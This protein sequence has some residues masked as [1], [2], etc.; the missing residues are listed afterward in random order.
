MAKKKKKKG[1]KSKK[2]LKKERAAAEKARAAEEAALE[3]A[4]L[5]AEAE[6]EAARLAAEEAIAAEVARQEAER[7]A[8]EEAERKAK[9][10]QARKRQALQW[11]A[12]QNADK[13]AQRRK[14]ARAR[15]RS[16]REGL[17]VTVVE[18]KLW[19]SHPFHVSCTVTMSPTEHTKTTT[20]LAGA[21]SHPVWGLPASGAPVEPQP[22][23]LAEP[24]APGER[25]FFECGSAYRR[26]MV[27]TLTIEVCDDARGTVGYASLPLQDVA[28]RRFL[29]FETL[30]K[31]TVLNEQ[32]RRKAARK[33]AKAALERARTEAPAK[34]LL[35]LTVETVAAQ[36]GVELEDAAKPPD[37]SSPAALLK[38]Q[39]LRQE[40]LSLDL[41]TL[42]SRALA[43]G[44][45]PTAML[46]VTEAAAAEVL[47]LQEARKEELEDSEEE[48]DG[49]DDGNGSESGS[50]RPSS[51]S[52]SG[53]RRRSSSSSTP[54]RKKALRKGASPRKGS[55]RPSTTPHD[56]ETRVNTPIARPGST[57]AHQRLNKGARPES[58]KDD[59][60]RPQSQPHPA[61]S[62]A[63]TPVTRP[64]STKAHQRL[65][66]GTKSR[67]TPR[68]RGSTPGSSRSRKMKQMDKRQKKKDENK[69][70]EMLGA[71]KALTLM[72]GGCWFDR[73]YDL[74]NELDWL[75]RKIWVKLRD[76]AGQPDEPDGSAGKVFL[77]LRA[78]G[79]EI[80][81]K[82]GE[83]MPE[84]EPG[85]E[86][87]DKA[88]VAERRRLWE[89]DRA[90]FWARVASAPVGRIAEPKPRPAL[91]AGW[92][93]G[94]L[95]DGDLVFFPS[96]V[97]GRAEVTRVQLLCRQ[98]N[99]DG[100][101]VLPREETATIL[102]ELGGPTDPDA[103]DEAMAAMSSSIDTERDEAVKLVVTKMLADKPDGEGLEDEN[104]EEPVFVTTHEL[105]RWWMRRFYAP[106]VP[107]QTLPTEPLEQALS[108]PGGVPDPEDGEL[109]VRIPVPPSV[110]RRRRRNADGS[111]TEVGTLVVPADGAP[112]ALTVGAGASEHSLRIEGSG[113]AVG[114]DVT[115]ELE[116]EAYDG[117]LQIK[118]LE[119][120]QQLAGSVV[121]ISATSAVAG[122][123][124]KMFDAGRVRLRLP[125]CHAGP[126]A[127]LRV[128][129]ER[130]TVSGWKQ[131]D[132]GAAL[133]D[134]DGHVTFVAPR[135]GRFVVARA[136]VDPKAQRRGAAPDLDRV[137]ILPTPRQPAGKLN[138]FEALNFSLCA[139]PHQ[140][141]LLEGLVASA[142]LGDL[143][144]WPVMDAQAESSTGFGVSS[145]GVGGPFVVVRGQSVGVQVVMPTEEPPPSEDPADDDGLSV[146]DVQTP[147]AGSSQ[148]LMRSALNSARS[149]LSSA[150][151]GLSSA[152]A[153][154]SSARASL[155]SARAFSGAGSSRGAR[156]ADQIAMGE[157]ELEALR[158]ELGSMRARALRKRALAEGIE[159]AQ[160]KQA[161]STR[162]SKAALVELIMEKAEAEAKAAAE[163]A[164]APPVL[165]IA[166]L[167]AETAFV[168]LNV[169]PVEW[170][171]QP[172]ATLKLGMRIE[173]D[174]STVKAKMRLPFF[175]EL[176]FDIP[177]LE[178]EEMARM[179]LLDKKQETEHQQAGEQA[180]ILQAAVKEEVVGEPARCLLSFASD[181]RPWPKMFAGDCLAVH[182]GE[183]GA[184]ETQT[185]QAEAAAEAAAEHAAATKL[186]KVWRGK[187]GRAKQL[188]ALFMQYDYDG[189]GTLERE[190]VSSL[191]KKL[192]AAAELENIDLTMARMTGMET[193]AEDV[194]MG[195][196]I[197]A[198]TT[199]EFER[200]WKRRGTE[201][202]V[203]GASEV[204]Y[205]DIHAAHL[206]AVQEAAD[207]EARAQKVALKDRVLS[208]VFAM[209]TKPTGWIRRRRERDYVV[210]I[211]DGVVV[212]DVADEKVAKLAEP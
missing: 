55:G 60:G 190:E 135:Q 71:T 64:G 162:D 59:N 173:A 139:F 53:S 116:V 179:A 23:P 122:L 113:A 27:P 108:L 143:T 6:I 28:R 73:G 109:S 15:L 125:H 75:D 18:A 142:G 34:A 102:A 158:V 66:K 99:L 90:A 133:A 65:N 43:C 140:S 33:E 136:M 141:G 17:T 196:A 112:A 211:G 2:E 1:K 110:P 77:R 209:L 5:A 145:V 68:S 8:K 104:E 115:L 88:E 121:T 184:D 198:V 93:C 160:V 20:T 194:A 97:G 41:P 54:R 155:S 89:D 176:T 193:L 165:K 79:P 203:E 40:L 98:H 84:P 85:L 101:G 187:V 14:A 50:D 62:R 114:G 111:L 172:A 151:S 29:D 94:E 200:W 182:L 180:L 86:P 107:T 72:A 103:V 144:Q 120:R 146:S 37:E 47:A 206:Q 100:S 3:E 147:R 32:E 208:F 138:T 161:Q 134:G 164:M 183:I 207:A 45:S 11:A 152:R 186:Q 61:N 117:T 7:R 177:K 95:E 126:P 204:V 197:P 154:L 70:L 22:D 21:C 181:G 166:E 205:G 24:T 137:F 9:E 119:P 96:T 82:R 192:G 91:P 26:G 163:A 178:N 69:R 81:D 156:R 44:V 57:K 118:G 87:L 35:D 202:S 191:L 185:A 31:T 157:A 159:E 76:P 49:D 48:E 199:V 212:D 174:E 58:P 210:P 12:A 39:Q 67:G 131:I 201:K 123:A 30:A 25:L 195:M 63:N 42:K 80:Q 124:T 106:A 78:C 127:R 129:H 10:L 4:R 46:E 128:L 13:E 105:E 168:P 148:R 52:S 188:K 171:G 150:R 16:H 19:K 130:V 169:T 56:S 51:V 92:A 74:E 132:R 189:S 36:E 38:V 170:W 175:L 167:P 153:S 149:S 83:P